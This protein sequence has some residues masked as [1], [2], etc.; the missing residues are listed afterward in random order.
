MYIAIDGDSVGVQ[1]QRLILEE[2]LE[3]LK[4]FSASIQQTLKNFVNVIEHNGGIVYMSGGDNI[5][6][7]GNEVCIQAVVQAVQK[8]NEKQRLYYSM[9][10]GNSTQDA[11]LGLKYAK[12]CKIRYIRVIRNQ[13]HIE[14]RKLVI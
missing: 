4:G 13:Y 1:L 5:F 8:E 9:A 2:R 7:E 12:S 3:E 14:F 6:A 10:I 11:Y